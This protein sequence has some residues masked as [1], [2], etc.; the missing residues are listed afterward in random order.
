MSDFK[1]DTKDFD[2][3]FEKLV[4]RTFPSRIEKGEVAAASEMLRDADKE[5]PRT[6]FKKGDLRGSKKIEPVKKGIRDIS[7]RLGYNID[8]AAK[9]HEMEKKRADKINWSLKGSG[10]K[11]LESKMVRNKKKYMEIVATSIKE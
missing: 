11:F 5:I 7:I 3:K 6:P 8:Y 10:P 2:M 4:K 9:L 1:L